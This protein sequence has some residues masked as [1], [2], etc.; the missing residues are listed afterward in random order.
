M[1]CIE[2]IVVESG[3]ILD[4]GVEVLEGE[5]EVKRKCIRGFLYALKVQWGTS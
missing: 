4:K 2:E 3:G 5:M 1:R